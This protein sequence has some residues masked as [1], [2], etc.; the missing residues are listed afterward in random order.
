VS[1]AI[2]GLVTNVAYGVAYY[3]YGVLIDP[4]HISAGWSLAVLA[5]TFSAVLVIGGAGGLAGGRLVDRLGPR[6]AFLIAAALGSGGLVIASVPSGLFA[7]AVPYALGCGVISALGFY[8]ITQPSAM[9]AA[10]D[11]RDRAVVW[12]TILGAFASPIFL[13]LTAWLVHTLGWPGALRVHAA[14]TL[15]IFTAAALASPRRAPA[16][17]HATPS[18]GRARDALAAAWRAPAFRRW[19]AASMIGGAAMDIILINQV[20]AMIAA[21][22]STGA[23]ATIGGLRGLAQLGGR[24]PLTPVMRRLGTRATIVASLLVGAAGAALLLFS[25]HIPVAILYSALA[26]TSIGAV[27]TLQGI[28]THELVGEAD[29]ALVMGAQQALFAI[30]GALG[31]IIAGVLLETAHS[32]T[33]ILLLTTAAFLIAATTIATGTRPQ[34]ADP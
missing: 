10:G 25:G 21:G 30:G 13:P 6:P 4:I 34:P 18:H 22:L 29:L 9:R 31:P 33:P 16:A 28:Y 26:G 14:L 24:I 20:P 32:Y 12:L 2:L 1:V 7:F 3:S 17:R 27:Y 19:I 8:H 11:Q 23:A 5:A 15:V